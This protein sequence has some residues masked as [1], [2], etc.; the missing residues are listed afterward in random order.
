M[1]AKCANPQCTAQFYSLRH[2]RLFVL[3][4]QSPSTRESPTVYPILQRERLEYFWLCERCCKIMRVGVDRDHRVLVTS[5]E[6]PGAKPLEVLPPVP[7]AERA[8]ARSD[9]RRL[10]RGSDSRRLRT[11]L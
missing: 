8:P 6:D 7:S 3:D 11:T 10:R 1:L 4:A 2:G 5:L 9:G